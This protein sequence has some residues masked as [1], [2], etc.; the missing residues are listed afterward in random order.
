MKL[1][2]RAPT[3]PTDLVQGRPVHAETGLLRKE[4]VGC[5][6]RAAN[7]LDGEA[8]PDPEET[9]AFLALRHP[10]GRTHR[11]GG[12]TCRDEL[13]FSMTRSGL[14]FEPV[15]VHPRAF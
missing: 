8:R 6:G 13:I 4:A 12:S 1:K 5:K 3:P 7:L 2:P 14:T 15:A 9:P 10:P 11:A